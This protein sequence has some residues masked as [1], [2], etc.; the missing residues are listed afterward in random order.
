ME[1]LTT[2]FGTIDILVDG[3]PVSYEARRGPANK[4]VW[5]DVRDIYRIGIDFFPDGKAHVLSCVFSPVCRYEQGE[6]SGQDLECQA[7]YGAGGTKM[8][9]GLEG[10]STIMNGYDYDVAYLENGMSYLIL[11]HTKTERYVFGIAWADVRP[12]KDGRDRDVQTWFA[13]DPTFVGGH[14][15]NRA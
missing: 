6:E 1:K 15:E 2:P 13:A 4:T 3:E 9:I 12:G 7:F 8:S 10:D 14:K 5:P 11:P